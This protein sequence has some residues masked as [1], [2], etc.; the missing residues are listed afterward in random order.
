MDITN[1]TRASNAERESVVEQLGRHMAEGRIDLT[2][3]D[4][5]VAHV[6]AALTRDDVNTVLADLPASVPV[7]RSDSPAGPH[8][9]R[10]LPI[11]QRI[12]VAAWLGVGLLNIIIWAAVSIGIGTM[13]YPWPVWVIGPWGAVLAFR[14][15][16]GF[17]SSR[18]RVGQ[19]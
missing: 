9:R 2:E 1:S 6:Y 12:E 8:Q 13:V 11:W 5:R 7:V 14:M 16:T 10:R 4:R 3:Y 18:R 15:I 17:E 19:W